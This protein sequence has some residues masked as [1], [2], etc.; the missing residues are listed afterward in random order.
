ME[1]LFAGQIGALVAAYI[2]CV[3]PKI[4]RCK[5]KTHYYF[6]HWGVVCVSVSSQPFITYHGIPFNW[7][8]SPYNCCG[9]MLNEKYD[10]VWMRVFAFLNGLIT[11]ILRLMC[12]SQKHEWDFRHDVTPFHVMS[13]FPFWRN[14][15]RSLGYSLYHLFG[16]SPLA[17]DCA[18]FY[19]NQFVF[20]YP[21]THAKHIQL[22]KNSISLWIEQ[23][24][25]LRQQKPDY[26]EYA[27]RKYRKWSLNSCLWIQLFALPLHRCS[28][29]F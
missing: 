24:L 12:T 20:Y 6:G 18:P 11:S 29:I 13:F 7:M 14:T 25:A 16:W 22:H 1:F 8:C 4:A 26:T 21:D 2:F 28:E 19:A 15:L 3:L 27:R 17:T 9:Q 23:C 10:E 5:R